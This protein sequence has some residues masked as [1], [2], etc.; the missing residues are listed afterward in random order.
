[1]KTLTIPFILLLTIAFSACSNQ[2]QVTAETDDIYYS[3]KDRAVEQSTNVTVVKPEPAPEFKGE[4]SS[5]EGYFV[6]GSA[7]NQE[8]TAEEAYYSEDEAA[9]ITTTT[10]ED[11]TTVNNFYGTTNY[12]ESD[13]DAA[14]ASRIRRFNSTNVVVGYSYYDP[15]FID[16]YWN[17]GWSS[18]DPYY[19][20]GWNLGWNSYA[21]WN[22]GYN[23]NSWY[24]RYNYYGYGNSYY[25]NRWRYRDYYAGWGNP[26]YYNGGYGYNSYWN[27]YNQGYGDGWNDGAYGN[28]GNRRDIYTGR[29]GM[30]N[31]TGFVNKNDRSNSPNK[32][33]QDKVSG[34]PLGI[35]DREATAN[36]QKDGRMASADRLNESSSI[37]KVNAG[38]LGNGSDVKKASEMGNGVSTNNNAQPSQVKK[39]AGAQPVNSR[40]K[41]DASELARTAKV[42]RRYG[43]TAVR[44]NAT[45]TRQ[46]QSGVKSDPTSVKSTSPTPNRAAVPINSGRGQGTISTPQRPN[47][48]GSAPS[49]T[50]PSTVR[51]P[52]YYRSPEREAAPQKESRD[53]YQ[54]QQP[55]RQER[56]PS[57]D[58]YQQ[59]PSARPSSP[60]RMETPS[61]QTPSRNVSPSR[62]T[63]PS[64]GS[65]NAPS[66]SSSPSRSIDRS[67]SSP[68][69]GSFST[70]SR[71]SS[72]GGSSMSS[73]S[74]GSRGSMN[75][76]GR[77]R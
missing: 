47:N 51:K 50:V 64:R 27:G 31:E 41:Y 57:Y 5:D 61:Q 10:S 74:K 70:P 15:Y 34:R 25:Y 35:V 21:G 4:E 52:N 66:R 8:E 63:S 43:H 28:G 32:A 73:P 54:Y 29:R 16:P 75:S 71:S 24:P 58:G 59:K 3:G 76:G 48:D 68:S 1:M 45:T 23:W 65:Y 56:S 7:K 77:R 42:D 20:S 17:Y 19:G 37:Y 44:N 49:R 14:Y 53:R 12:Y 72:P 13:E 22:I 33:V 36:A 18:R 30:A 55:Q 26:Y 39:S 2:R 62:S 38:R 67:S 6:K 60:Q 69:R 46:P 9:R 11:G 40:I